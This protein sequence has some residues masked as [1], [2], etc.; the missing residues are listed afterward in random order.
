MSKRVLHLLHVD[1][2]EDDRFLFARCANQLSIPFSLTAARG[3]PEAL[4]N[5]SE[6]HRLPDLI[7]LDIKMPGMGGF[8]V[9]E[10]LKA[11]GRFSSIPVVMLSSSN[12]PDDLKRAETLGAYSYCVK[13]AGLPEYR[14]LVTH[15]YE[16]WLHSTRPCPSPEL[17]APRT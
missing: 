4:Q 17:D 12:H 14:T 6:A 16:S 15:I 3:G 11:D 8:E 10:K 1:D 7:L 5:L 9:L 13:P 2:S